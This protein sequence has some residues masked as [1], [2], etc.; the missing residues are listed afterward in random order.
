MRNYRCRI[1]EFKMLL[2]VT[3]NL[4]TGNVCHCSSVAYM[5]QTAAVIR[6]QKL[7]II[8]LKHVS[9]IMKTKQHHQIP[10]TLHSVM[11][12]TLTKCRSFASAKRIG[13]NIHILNPISYSKLCKLLIVLESYIF[14]VL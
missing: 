1:Y 7:V 10:L 2:L 8:Q 11:T 12:A 3:N 13:L 4:I 5:Q 14:K 9:P 6:L